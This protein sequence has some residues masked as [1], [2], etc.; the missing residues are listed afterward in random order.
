MFLPITEDWE[1]LTNVSQPGRQ[2]LQKEN[3]FALRRP[4]ALPPPSSQKNR[5]VHIELVYE[6][7]QHNLGRIHGLVNLQKSKLLH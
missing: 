1:V 4:A 6:I 3:A 2:N 5:L 7:T